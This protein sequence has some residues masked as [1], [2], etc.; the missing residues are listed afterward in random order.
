MR[1]QWMNGQM[2]KCDNNWID[3]PIGRWMNRW[4]EGWVSGE[5]MDK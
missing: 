5:W 3:R 2:H 4:K 1:K